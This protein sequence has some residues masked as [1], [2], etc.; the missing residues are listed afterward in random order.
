MQIGDHFL[1]RIAHAPIVG[2]RRSRKVYR[3]FSVG[4]HSG[5]RPF[6]RVGS[7]GAHGFAGQFAA[8]FRRIQ[9]GEAV[10][11]PEQPVAFDRLDRPV[12]TG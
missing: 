9:I 11:V 3:K 4:N 10:I 2:S 5:K 1:S 6:S 7:R 8:V 12:L